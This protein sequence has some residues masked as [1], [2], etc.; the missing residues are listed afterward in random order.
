MSQRKLQ[1]H[2]SRVASLALAVLLLVASLPAAGAAPTS[3]TCGDGVNWTLSGGVLTVSGSGDMADY[4]EFTPAPWAAHADEV[5]SVRVEKGVKSVGEFAFFQ[6]KS[7]SAVTL[8]SSVKSVGGYAFY[9]C[10][11]LALLD[12]GSVEVIGTSGFERCASLTSVRLPN[13][14]TTLRSQAFYRCEKLASIVVPSSVREMEDTVFG[15]CANLRSAVVLANLSTLPRWTFYGCY[16]LENVS[17]APAITDIGSNAFEHCDKLSNVT[18]NADKNTSAGYQSEPTTT[19]QGDT[20]VTTSDGYAE[21]TESAIHTQTTTTKSEQGENT[22]VKIDAVLEN[23][24]GWKDVEKELETLLKGA[25]STQ[26][27]VNLKGETTVSGADLGRFAGKD[28][29]V[30]IRTPQGAQWYFNGKDLSANDLAKKYDLSFTLKELT[31]PDEKQSEALGEAQGFVVEFH[32]DID[33]KVE[34]ELPLGAVLARQSA[35]FFTPGENGYTRAQ[36][37]MID[38]AGIAHFYL[39]QVQAETEYLIGINVPG[40][41]DLSDLLIPPAMTHEYPQLEQME[42]IRYVVTGTK[43]SLGINIQQLTIIIVA[44]L[45]VSFIVVGFVIFAMNK[46]KL[47]KGYVPVLDDEDE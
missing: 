4:G 36:A 31:D 45:V 2:I 42:E 1:L 33:F 27:T 9:G 46:K 3:G 37:V 19:Q 16:A 6:M 28:T 41:G 26:V 38:T 17:L 14:L 44:V 39:A 43:N 47:K 34:V 22:S 15:Y 21:T 24:D 18:T 40:K 13:T 30:T 32:E 7:I 29:T 35:V 5:K 8:A 12:L 11:G 25:D 20:T 10:S 23:P